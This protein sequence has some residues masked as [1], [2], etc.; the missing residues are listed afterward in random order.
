MP[1]HR[2]D[3]IPD[4]PDIRDLTYTVTRRTVR[5]KKVDLRK[6][7]SP[8][9]DQGDLG[10]CTGNAIVG[11]LEYLTPGK[12]LINLSRLFVYYQE[13]VIEGDVGQDNGAQIRDGVKACA[14]VG[15][16]SEQLWPY[17]IGR[18]AEPPTPAAN[19]DAATRKI[20]EYVRVVGLNSMLQRL[21]EGFPVIFGFSV[22]ESF[23]S[24][25]VASTGTVPM[26]SK[27]EQ[28]LGGHA[29]LAVGYDEASKRVTVRNSWGLD[30]G[31]KGYFTMPYAYLADRNLSDDFWTIRK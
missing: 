22:Y 16:C 27:N 17:D 9:E 8:V 18:F 3:W 6:H 2:Y 28:L 15:V 19:A 12:K 13:R 14:K 29:V 20:K 25:Q 7:C 26:P 24:D 10:S 11:A 1:V 31:K 4:L 23:E 30:W 21:S 5:P